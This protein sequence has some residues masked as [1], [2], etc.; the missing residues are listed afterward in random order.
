MNGCRHP[1][2]AGEK[3]Q[4][5]PGV[6]V[7]LGG[8]SI[9]PAERSFVFHLNQSQVHLAGLLL[10]TESTRISLSFAMPCLTLDPSDD[11]LVLLCISPAAGQHLS[12]CLDLPYTC[13]SE[14]EPAHDHILVGL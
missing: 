13:G 5:L 4:S 8:L 12:D 10:P 6:S 3:P 1:I 2:K 9:L 14:E 11:R 7:S